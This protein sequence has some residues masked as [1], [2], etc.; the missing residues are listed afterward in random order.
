M[1]HTD[2]V[3]IKPRGGQGSDRPEMLPQHVKLDAHTLLS[4]NHLTC[5]EAANALGIS[6]STLK[7]ACRRLGFKK[8]VRPKKA[9]TKAA[10]KKVHVPKSHISNLPRIVGRSLERMLER[11]IDDYP[12]TYPLMDES[13]TVANGWTAPD[14]KYLVT[15]L[16]VLVKAKPPS[17]IP[18]LPS[19][20]NT[21][22]LQRASGHT[23]QALA[24][25]LWREL[26]GEDEMN[27]LEGGTIELTL[28]GDV[29]TS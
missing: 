19:L 7:Y 17:A 3:I 24:E 29:F 21:E 6:L 20:P 4:L 18:S 13:G 23:G 28:S 12:D 11:M 22:Y 2:V 27:P 14:L 1:E 9:D 15:P 10:K 5:H 26:G 8:W 25:E 16:P